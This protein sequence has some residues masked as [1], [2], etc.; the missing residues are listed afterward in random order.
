MDNRFDKW[1]KW[2]DSIYWEITNLSRYRNIFWEVQ[3]IIKNNPRI[4]KQS[5]FYE[6]LGVSYVAF[7]LMGIRRQV[8][9]HKDSISFARLLKEIY[10]TPEVLSRTRFVALYKGSIVEH[11]AD[12]DFDQ[13]SGKAR[14][15]VDP[16][17]V[18]KDHENLKE[19]AK[20]FE[21]YA[22]RRIA[23]LDK[24]KP[25]TILKF[26]DVDNCIDFLEKLTKKYW[27]LF[28]GE[29]VRNILPTY[30]YD[31]KAI[32]KEPWLP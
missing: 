14:S 32:F 29:Y 30:P 20:G 3:G 15:H 21:T 23:H 27:L 5:S 2:L 31:W 8:K 17:I 19:K 24:R 1:N 13:F 7:V 28:R 11:Y 25:K 9:I 18:K 26:K 12:R 4:Q 10:E 6:F 16:I 22:D